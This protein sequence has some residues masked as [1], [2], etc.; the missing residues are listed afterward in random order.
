MSADLL[1]QRVLKILRERRN[2]SVQRLRLCKPRMPI[3][4]SNG[5]SA[6]AVTPSASAEEIA[7]H[8]VDINATVDALD[9]AIAIVQEEYKKIVS[10]EQ[11]DEDDGKEKKGKEFY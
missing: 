7:L 1:C 4:Q 5:G 6:M 9:N 3:V 8:A 2:D 11:P 10:P